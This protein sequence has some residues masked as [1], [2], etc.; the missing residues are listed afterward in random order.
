M[1]RKYLFLFTVVLT[2]LSVPV[3]AQSDLNHEAGVKTGV[4]AYSRVDNREAV[5]LSSE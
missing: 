3:W 2:F 1:I 4:G 5:E